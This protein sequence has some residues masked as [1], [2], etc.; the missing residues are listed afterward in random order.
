[1][2]A[3]H[4]TRQDPSPGRSVQSSSPDETP[5]R[6]ILVAL[7]CLMCSGISEALAQAAPEMM[8]TAVPEPK[9]PA[10]STGLYYTIPVRATLYFPTDTTRAYMNL[11][12]REPVEFLQS[13]DPGWEGWKRVRT[14]DGANG[15]V[16]TEEVTNVWLRISKASQT[17][18]VYRGEHLVDR[19]PTDLGYNFF[20]DK[21]RRGSSGDPDH[22]RT[23]EGEFFVANKNAYSQFYKAFVLN[24]PNA[25]DAARGL[26]DGLITE[27]QYEQIVHAE[28]RF[29]MPPMDTELGGWIEIHGDG[30]GERQNWT[31]GCVAIQNVQMDR[32]WD[33]IEVGTPVLI[34]R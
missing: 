31:Q 28:N 21:E 22:W 5:V 8:V 24:Y 2:G 11:T 16:R 27:E 30:T 29:Q 17:L 19:I 32:L 14:L 20:S 26:E 1:M 7:A 33:M 9:V 13:E 23:P 18:F 34:T 3:L 4:S 12:R 15:L 25:E 10:E 6:A